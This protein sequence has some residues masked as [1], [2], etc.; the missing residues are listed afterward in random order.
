VYVVTEDW[1]ERMSPVSPRSGTGGGRGGGGEVTVDA[2]EPCRAYGAGG[3]MRVPGRLYVSWADESTLQV[4]MDAGTQ[5]RLFHFDPAGPAPEANSLQG[6]SVANWEGGGGGRGRGGGTSWGALR[7]VTTSL[8]EGYLLSRRSGY[9]EGAV[10]TET[11]MLHSDFGQ[12]YLTVR[13]ELVDGNTNITS[14]T[15]KREPDG[16]NFSPTGCEIVR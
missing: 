15:F 1:I 8:T 13:A 4:D 6:Y 5:T 3:S 7:V 2:S 9:G 10:L 11:F 14:S 12:E 16:S